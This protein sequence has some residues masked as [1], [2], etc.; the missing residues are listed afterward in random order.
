MNDLV[1]QKRLNS[2][3]LSA[4]DLALVR[5]HAAFAHNRL[6]RLLTELHAQFANWPEIQ[7]ALMLPDVHAARMAHW[8]R[9]ASGDLGD[10]FEASAERLATA[11]S[12]HGVPAYA[13]VVCHFTVSRAIYKELG[14]DQP[15]PAGLGGHLQLRG[16]AERQ[17]LAAAIEKLAWFDL[18]MLLETYAR[19]EAERRRS[20]MARLEA[21]QDKVQTIVQGVTTGAGVVSSRSETTVAATVETAQLASTVAGSSQ[22]ASHNVD[23]VA[24]AAEELSASLDEVSSQI[25]RAASIAQ[26][27]NLAAQQTDATV[28]GLSG[29]AG[30]IGDVVAL[31]SNIASQTNLLALN[32]T[33]EAA[34]AREAGRG[35]AVVAAEVKGLAGQTAKATEE[36]TAQVSAMQGA[37]QAAVGAIGQIA[38]MIGELDYVAA[39]MATAIAQQGAATQEI[40]SNVTQAASGTQQVAAS[41]DG[42]S[43]AARTAGNAA[44]ELRE[45][46]RT[47]SEQ[48]T[49]LQ[50]AM[51][52][53]IAQNRAA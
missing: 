32:A 24:A 52:E 2:F 44:G 47:L 21:F 49:A 1:H 8:V 9:A 22:E 46:A 14:L 10:G 5:S 30:R 7:R 17:A 16:H 50:Q 38:A 35:F 36:I 39:T 20:A 53:L 18:E 29:S 33:I 51:G 13:V 48:A 4:A 23:G 25:A 15:L 11:F 45:V 34:R 27:A 12:Q 6:P 43:A 3:Q 31:I 28:Q 42:V 40:A 41:I 19:V 26:S 37:T